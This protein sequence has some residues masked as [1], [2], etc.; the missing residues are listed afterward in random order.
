MKA[1]IQRVSKAAVKIRDC[2]PRE[3]SKGLVVFLGI[4]PQD[5][6]KDITWLSKKIVNL[7]VFNKNKKM[8]LSI[9]DIKGSL[10]LISQFTLYGD[11]MKGNRPSFLNAAEPVHAKR[12]YNEFVTYITNQDII[13]EVGDF[14]SH[15]E[16]S[17]IN[18][19]PVTLILDT[20]KN[21]KQ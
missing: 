8:E 12:I 2:P 16:V 20:Q 11:C 6:M 5:S 17:L 19:G 15:M 1:I 7:R 4:S 14:G 3:I 10:L 18:D 21:V 9:K 13:V